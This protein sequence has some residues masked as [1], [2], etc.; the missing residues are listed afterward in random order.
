M[1][2]S[3]R[4]AQ[5]WSQASRRVFFLFF[6]LFGRL[7]HSVRVRAGVHIAKVSFDFRGEVAWL[8]FLSFLFSL[9]LLS[10][11]L[12]FIGFFNS[13]FGGWSSALKS[14]GCGLLEEEAPFPLFFLFRGAQ[15]DRREALMSGWM[16]RAMLGVL[17]TE[18][19]VFFFFFL[20]F[21]LPAIC[22]L[23][24]VDFPPHWPNYL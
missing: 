21:L 7:L 19:F 24:G 4:P 14:G 6:F 9:L 13:C 10:Q 1:E 22:A 15:R 8:A 23:V 3:G 11:T 5:K 12:P 16:A 18:R 20:F 17:G 2:Q